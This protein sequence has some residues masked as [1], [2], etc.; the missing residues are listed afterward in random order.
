MF[1]HELN[2]VEPRFSHFFMK[3]YKLSFHN[4]HGSSIWNHEQC[5]TYMWMHGWTMQVLH[6]DYLQCGQKVWQYRKLMFFGSYRAL[7]ELRLLI[8]AE[9]YP[10]KNYL[11]EAGKHFTSAYIFL[12]KQSFSW[13]VLH[14][15][16]WVFLLWKTQSDFLQKCSFL[17]STKNTFALSIFQYICHDCC[18]ML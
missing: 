2:L 15:I 17:C 12:E 7:Q 5:V 8:K 9:V 1:I 14:S 16:F 13:L 4:F 18:C 3:W 11:H 10:S 6:P